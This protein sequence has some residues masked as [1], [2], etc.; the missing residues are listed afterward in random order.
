[1]SQVKTIPN[2]IFFANVMELLGEGQSVT[3]MVSGRSMS[4]TF[5]DKVDKIVISPFNPDN[6]AAGDVVLFDRGDTICV[7][8]IIERKGDRLV[9]RGDGN[10]M[11]ALERV[12]VSAVMGLVTGGTMYGGKKFSSDGTVWKRNTRFVLRFFPLIALFHRVEF[13]VKRYPL[14][15]L[16]SLF[17]MY[18]SFFKPSG[19]HIVDFEN[20]DKLAHTLMY[21]GAS[22]VF[23]F[24]WLRWHPW[25]GRKIV[26]GFF[27]CFIIPIV[28]GGVL[29]LIQ[30]YIIDYRSGEWLDFISDIAGVSA[31]TVFSFAVTLPLLRK[32]VK[33]NGNPR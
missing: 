33:K 25:P 20:A 15:I 2:E 12:K 10:G 30:E 5:K 14:S 1:M 23:W 7:H 18:L 19:K 8:R 28:L 17:L 4:P 11:K 9:I 26:R 22:L 13:I 29:E 21:F 6:L 16:A 24:E 32:F 27:L 31:A 3:I